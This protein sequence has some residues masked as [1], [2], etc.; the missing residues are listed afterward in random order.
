MK[1]IHI[2]AFAV[3]FLAS[4]SLLSAQVTY[5][6][7]DGVSDS[8][9]GQ[10]DG[11]DLL[12]GNYFNELPNGEVVTSVSLAFRGTFLVGRPF[13][14]AIYDDMDNDG[15]PTTNLSLLATMADTVAEVGPVGTDTF[16]VV[17]IPDTVISGGFFVAALMEGT[18][19]PTFPAKLDQT[20]TQMRS[21]FA[22]N[23]ISG[24][25]DIS[26]PFGITAA[27]SGLIDDAGLPGNWLIRAHAV[28]IPEPSSAAIS[29]SA[30]AL[31]LCRRRVPRGK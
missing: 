24:A 13:Q 5:V 23:D 16:Q 11:G 10:S 30:C 14:V 8:A 12:W 15:D 7:D 17:D 22:E 2:V 6:I 1:R 26:D 21:W 27:S 28:P 9:P 19:N 3:C 18:G 25:L 31:F 20:T 29:L 4:S